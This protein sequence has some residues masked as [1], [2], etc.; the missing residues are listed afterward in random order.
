MYRRMYRDICK[1]NAVNVIKHD[2]VVMAIAT[3]QV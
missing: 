2:D 1:C 3:I